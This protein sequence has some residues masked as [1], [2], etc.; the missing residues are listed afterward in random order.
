VFVA[1][2]D[3]RYVAVNDYACSLLGYSRE[4]LLALRVTD[5]A[6]YS[7]APR[8]YSTMMSGGRSTGTSRLSR[9]DGSAISVSFLAQET[10]VAHMLL[11]V[12][13]A[14]PTGLDGDS[15]P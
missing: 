5:V 6:R 1:D 3:M 15:G 7:E 10:K 13:V 12:S 4:E 2:E 8:E 9:K 11:Y 14:W